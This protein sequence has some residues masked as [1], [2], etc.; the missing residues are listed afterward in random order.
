MW[1]VLQL[2]P[3]DANRVKP[4]Q[5]VRFRYAAGAGPAASDS[6]TVA[7]ISPSADEKTRTVP[8]RVDL[9]NVSDR[10]HANTFGTAEVVLREEKDALVV[11]NGAVH[12]DGCCNVVFVRDTNYEKPGTPKVVHVRKVRPG[13]K[14]VPA[15]A[16]PVTEIAAGLL[17][18]EWVATTNSG[19]FRSELL[20]NDLGAG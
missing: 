2:R 6:G 20:K 19:I 17:P 9:P 15:A 8:V 10:H 18:G 13:A 7:W 3:E 12:W 16:G 14:D 4:G 1:L 5:P 11:P